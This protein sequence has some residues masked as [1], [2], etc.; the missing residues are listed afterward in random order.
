MRA[1]VIAVLA[2]GCARPAPP[3]F[4]VVPDRA[5]G[6]TGA[7]LV[8][9]AIGVVSLA[10]SAFAKEEPNAPG[11]FGPPSGAE[12]MRGLAVLTFIPAVP[13]VLYGMSRTRLEPDEQPAALGP[14]TPVVLA[15]P[16]DA[17]AR[18]QAI[19][20][21]VEAAAAAHDGQC[22]TVAALGTRIQ[23]LDRDVHASVFTR[24]TA[25]H[26]CLRTLPPSRDDVR[27]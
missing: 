20:L 8:L 7:G 22:G 4:H 25:I 13:L 23:A 3:G 1:L 10:G 19:E 26:A 12:A 17:D 9:A 21:T 15:A 5:N 14:P 27:R 24:H 18:K 16:V 11:S 6:A 2:A